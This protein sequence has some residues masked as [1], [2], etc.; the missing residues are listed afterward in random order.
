MEAIEPVDCALKREFGTRDLERSAP[1][2]RGI[3]EWLARIGDD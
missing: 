1:G 2:R 3:E